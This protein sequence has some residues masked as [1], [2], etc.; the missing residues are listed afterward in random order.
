MW[1]LWSYELCSMCITGQ[2]KNPTAFQLNMI[3]MKIISNVCLESEGK[4]FKLAA[5][6]SHYGDYIH[7]SH[8]DEN[9]L[10][11]SFK[12]QHRYYEVEMAKQLPGSIS[13]QTGQH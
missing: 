1:L 2:P 5:W 3:F 12:T 7:H 13:K 4:H 10:E 8:T 11:L 6:N 9:K